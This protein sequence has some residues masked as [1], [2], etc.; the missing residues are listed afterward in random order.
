[1]SS[2]MTETIEQRNARLRLE[3]Q[4]TEARLEAQRLRGLIKEAEWAA[5]LASMCPWCGVLIG[6]KHADDC[7]AFLPDGRVR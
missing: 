2:H 4:V 1:M 6:D 5:Q 7:P 3:D